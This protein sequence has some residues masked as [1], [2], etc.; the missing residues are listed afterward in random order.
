MPPTDGTPGCELREIF[1]VKAFL[2]KK[3][4]TKPNN[5]IYKLTETTMFANFIEIQFLDG[6]EK[7]ELL[8]FSKL[9]TQER[10]KVAPTVITPFVP[11]KTTRGYPPNAAGIDPAKVYQYSIFPKLNSAEFVKSRLVAQA[12]EENAIIPS[13]IFKKED[14]V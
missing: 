1:N 7:Q 3:E 6:P 4:A 2:I 5:F 14:E 11:L 9:I 8:Y 10:T 13:V 12:S